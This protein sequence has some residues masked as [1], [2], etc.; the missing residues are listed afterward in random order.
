MSLV[1]IQLYLTGATSSRTG[2]TQK[3]CQVILAGFEVPS[4]NK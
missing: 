4:Y 3:I 2:F 1:N